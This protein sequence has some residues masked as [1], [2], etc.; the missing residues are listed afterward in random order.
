VPAAPI[1]PAP[2]SASGGV[3]VGGAA[4]PPA[5]D[6][7]SILKDAQALL[8]RRAWSEARVMLH[9]LA[10]RVPGDRSYRAL[11]AYARGRIAQDEGRTADARAEFERAVSLDPELTIAATALG[12]VG[13]TP[14]G[15]GGSFWSRLLKK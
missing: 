12:E 7:R 3:A 4:L 10:A 11:L 13:G 14:P 15:E 6:E 2:R 5:H 8:A 1:Q 9:D